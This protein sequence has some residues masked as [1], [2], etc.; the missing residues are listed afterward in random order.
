LQNKFAFLV[1]Y[2]SVIAP[3]ALGEAGSVG[4]DSVGADSV[5]ADSVGFGSVVTVAGSALS[6]FE[7]GSVCA[8]ESEITVGNESTF[9]KLKYLPPS[10]KLLSDASLLEVPQRVIISSSV[11]SASNCNVKEI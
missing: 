5:G 1:Y 9:A 11:V 6:C 10:S 3:S 8:F 2:H 4:V 7:A